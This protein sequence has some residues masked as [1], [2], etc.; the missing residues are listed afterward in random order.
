MHMVHI[1]I[2]VFRN[3]GILAHVNIIRKVTFFGDSLIEHQPVQCLTRTAAT[4]HWPVLLGK[5]V[6]NLR[7]WCPELQATHGQ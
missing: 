5:L 7:S 3:T 6:K 4:S 1:I 2:P